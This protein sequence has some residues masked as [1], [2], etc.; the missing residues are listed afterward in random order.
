MKFT[1]K[2]HKCQQT[3]PAFTIVTS[4]PHEALT[5]THARTLTR[6]LLPYTLQ[7]PQHSP[8]VGKKGR[9]RDNTPG[10]L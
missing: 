8:Q 7:A 2:T 1:A 6:T 9:K 10:G 3:S 4:Q 5:R